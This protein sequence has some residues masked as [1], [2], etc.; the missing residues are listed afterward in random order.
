MSCIIENGD[1]STS[2]PSDVF[3]FRWCDS[4]TVHYW[5]L[6]IARF[7]FC[8]VGLLRRNSINFLPDIS[9]ILLVYR[10]THD[11]VLDQF[12]YRLVVG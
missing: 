7:V 11:M 4:V 8:G 5:T 3:S 6:F 2:R 10:Y 1:E 9:N 12:Q